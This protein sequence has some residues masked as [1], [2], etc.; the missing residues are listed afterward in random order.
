[1]IRFDVIR[2]MFTQHGHRTIDAHPITAAEL[3]TLTSKWS[4]L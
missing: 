4:A 2:N 3:A 1:M